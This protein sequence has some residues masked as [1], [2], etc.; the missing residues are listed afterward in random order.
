[1]LKLA[2]Y[3]EITELALNPKYRFYADGFVKI[4]I[5]YYRA[6]IFVSCIR[7]LNNGTFQV[8]KFNYTKSLNKDITEKDIPTILQRGD[9]Y[10]FEPTEFNTLDLSIKNI[11][12]N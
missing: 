3:T 12:K 8:C 6:S 9:Y 5:T 1:M 7:P 4:F 10:S 11:L 2:T